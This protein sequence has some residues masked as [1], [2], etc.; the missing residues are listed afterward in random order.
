MAQPKGF[1]VCG[2]EKW[3]YKTKKAFYGFKQSS[4]QWYAHLKSTLETLG[5][6]HSHADSSL[7][8]MNRKG[9]A[10]FVFAYVDR[11]QVT[12][13]DARDI[14]SFIQNLKLHFTL[15]E[16]GSL[17]TFLRIS[18]HRHGNSVKLEH[19][20]MIKKWF[21]VF[22]L[23]DCHI[24]SCPRNGGTDFQMRLSENDLDNN[25]TYQAGLLMYLSNNTRRDISYAWGYLSRY[26]HRPRERLWNI[27]K[28]VLKYLKR[29]ITLALTYINTCGNLIK[30]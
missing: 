16:G 8:S 19:A 2:K 30:G 10:L 3:F 26:L 5:F 21:T 24:L 4:R 29:M 13:N 7:F 22:W 6:Y 25:I 23:E 14:G 27:A 9:D 11:F 15:K 17:E 20:A 18:I 1:D 28:S 12:W